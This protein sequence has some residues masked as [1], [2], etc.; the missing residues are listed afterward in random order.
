MIDQTGAPRLDI[1]HL[2]VEE[3][4]QSRMNGVH[5]VANRLAREQVRLGQTVRVVVLH[6]PARAV[7]RRP[8]P[9]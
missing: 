6:P 9:G 8:G 5:L 3:A 7:D 1:R 2:V 4:E